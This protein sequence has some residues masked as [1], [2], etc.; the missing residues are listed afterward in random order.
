MNAKNYRPI[1]MEHF[2]PLD[3]KSTEFSRQPKIVTRGALTQATPA[4]QSN[5]YRQPS[6]LIGNNYTPQAK[7]LNI[8]QI[9]ENNLKNYQNDKSIINSNSSKFE[10]NNNLSNHYGGWGYTTTNQNNLI[11]LPK[12][13]YVQNKSFRNLKFI[14]SSKT[15]VTKNKRDHSLPN[16]IEQLFSNVLNK[17]EKENTK[18]KNSL[19][20]NSIPKEDVIL[21]LNDNN[22]NI[23]FLPWY[24]STLGLTRPNSPDIN[25]QQ[26]Y[27][28]LLMNSINESMIYPLTNELLTKIKQRVNNF[29]LINNLRDMVEKY[30]KD[31]GEQY[32]WAIK[33]S[34]LD[35]IVKDKSEQERLG[36]KMIEK[37]IH[38][39]GRFNFPWH[40]S[41]INAR[42]LIKKRLFLYNNSIV[43]KIYYNFNLKYLNFRMI[44]L[45]ELINMMPMSLRDFKICVR[46]QIEQKKQYLI[47]NWLDQCTDL[48][49]LNKNS[50]DLL[51]NQQDKKESFDLMNSFFETI[52]IIISSRMRILI[53]KTLED[54]TNFLILYSNGNDYDNLNE[55][56]FRGILT[57]Q[58][59][60]IPFIIPLKL[61][62]DDSSVYLDPQ[63][64][65]ITETLRELYDDIT[66][67]LNN[68]PRLEN[69]VL[70][71]FQSKNFN[72]LEM[73]KINEKIVIE[74]KQKVFEIFEAN[75]QGPLNYLKTYDK[76]KYLISNN[77]IQ[78]T[79]IFVLRKNQSL[80]DYR[81]KI[82]YFKSLIEEISLLPQKIPL[83]IFMLDC[84]ELNEFLLDRANNCINIILDKILNDNLTLNKTI[85]E[86]FDKIV[87]TMTQYGATPEEC[88]KLIKYVENARFYE[89]YQLKEMVFESA[90][91]V[92][93]LVDYALFSKEDLKWNNYAF[94]WYDNIQ[95][96]LLNTELKLLKEKDDWIF[97]LKDKRSKLSLKIDDCFSRVKELRN[98][99]RI[100]DAKQ[101]KSDINFIS[102][103]IEEY[104]KERSEISRDEKILDLAET[105]DFSIVDDIRILKEPYDKLWSVTCRFF[106][107]QEKWLNNSIKNINAEDVEIELQDMWKISF[108]STKKF[109]N[110]DQ[111][112]PLRVALTIKHKIEK[113]RQKL[114]YIQVFCNPG[115]KQRH[116]D[117]LN[118]ILETKIENNESILLK[119]ILEFVQ[120]AESKLEKL[121][122][123]STL[124]AKEYALEQALK[125]MKASWE[126]MQFNFMQYKNENMFILSSFDDIDALLD[127]HYVKTT[128]MK[129]SPFV[130]A[131]QQDV[132][133]WESELVSFF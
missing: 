36:I 26:R 131:F 110:S 100:S 29:A 23:D 47:E 107:L 45:E 16:K 90:A 43:H 72:Y 95:P 99:D 106:S 86:R 130:S 10:S 3:S 60:I 63:I 82:D 15:F 48:I 129:N 14:K 49:L 68:L 81:K 133:E 118:T 6:D 102:Q 119:D 64:D 93:F 53:E 83:N 73:L 123:I 62:K 111:K 25:T 2:T 22:Y 57:T 124:A 114:P 54:L 116:W 24:T 97:R 39:A 109:T 108:Q 128:S 20:L 126:N 127:D 104:S 76:Y 9:Q 5:F 84:A 88:V 4:N 34:I 42:N 103:E 32:T 80:S 79:N 77:S 58:T 94:T 113:F 92:L 46:R 31:I 61:N 1:F 50:I 28:S 115:L 56:Q 74:L 37:E 52:S 17:T 66:N 12:I 8:K 89:C 71:N 96:M 122:M 98:K 11:K 105:V 87:Y 19:D 85:C 51:I 65:E 21:L 67:S 44:D 132:L 18:K 7:D 78:E 40:D 120:S 33:K 35:Y 27:N 69:L 101:I 30:E 55:T 38:S 117:S 91:N 70:H 125:K 112:G 121:T 41:L 13:D 59:S 75:R